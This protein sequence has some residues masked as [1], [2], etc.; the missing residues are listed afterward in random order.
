MELD[1][2]DLALLV[3]QGEGVH[4]KALHVAVVLRN[5]NIVQQEGELQAATR[6]RP[7]NRWCQRPV[8]QELLVVLA[9]H[10]HALRA[11]GEVVHDPAGPSKFRRMPEQHCLEEL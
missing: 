10:V 6:Q 5:T 7:G 2:G 8:H 4:A 11:V 1:V 3:D 9:H